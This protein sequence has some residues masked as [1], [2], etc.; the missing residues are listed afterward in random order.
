MLDKSLEYKSIVMK[1]D[2]SLV[3][4]VTVPE[5]PSGYAYR[6]FADGDE[7]HWA[8]LEAS[9]LEFPTEAAALSYF[10]R[11]FMPYRELLA[12]RC[13]FVTAPGGLPVA[14]ATAWYGDSVL[15]HQAILHWVSVDPAFQG[16][17]L[18]RA[19]TAKAVSLFPTLEP[20]Q[21][22]YLHTQTWSHVAIRL[23]RRIGFRMCKTETIAM[24]R[25]DGQGP[26]IYP[27]E[28]AG[29]LEV[30]KTVLPPAEI[31]ELVRT[32]V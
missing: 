29:A 13:V 11:D 26:K 6:L 19:V 32:A 17:G 4:A 31:D 8:R 1:M 9:V 7:N 5:L 27:N 25:N 23:Y 10:V 24:M 15:G 20:G 22:V 21:D 18:G 16:K 3:S 28:Y 2:A 30:L 14:T 12:Q